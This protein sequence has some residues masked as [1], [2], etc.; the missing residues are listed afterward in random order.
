MTPNN[1]DPAAPRTHGGRPSLQEAYPDI[2]AEWDYERNGDLTPSKVTPGS[3]QKAGWVCKDDPDHRW[4]AKIYNRTNGT[5]CPL[6]QRK[7]DYADS[8]AALYP[9][10]AAEWD[11][12][13]NGDL[14]PAKVT[15]GSHQKAG[16]ICKDDPDHRWTATINNRTK[17]TGC[18]LCPR[19]VDY[20]DSLAALYP[21]IAAEWD[22]EKNGDLTPS[23]VTPGSNQKAGWICKDDPEHRWTATVKNRTQGTGCPV[24][25]QMGWIDKEYAEFLAGIGERI[26]DL[27]PAEIL[28]IASEHGLSQQAVKRLF[29]KVKNGKLAF[30]EPDPEPEPEPADPTQPHDPSFPGWVDGP[31]RPLDP[32]PAGP[33]VFLDPITGEPLDGDPPGDPPVDPP[34]D[35]T[36]PGEE[37]ST[38]ITVG[39]EI[40]RKINEDPDRARARRL[41]Q[42]LLSV[43][44]DVMWKAAYVSPDKCDRA[45]GRPRKDKYEEQIRTAFR[46]EFDAARELSIPD[47]WRFAVDGE[48]TEPNLMQRHVASTLAR[49]PYFAN[50]SGTGAGKTLS[51]VLAAMS[52][53]HGRG[54]GLV[55]VVC[56]HNTIDGWVRTVTGCDHTSQVATKTWNPEWSQGIGPKWLVL[57]YE[58][59][60]DEDAQR[61]IEALLQQYRI[62]M[63]IVDEIHFG[64]ERRHTPESIRRGNLMSLRVKAGEQN[65]KLRVLGMSA[66]PVINEPKEAVSLLEILQGIE[67]PDLPVASTTVAA[68]RLHQE[69]VLAG[70]RWKPDYSDIAVVEK[71]IDV[72]ISHLHEEL[73]DLG[74]GASAL[75]MEMILMRGKVDTV[76]DA[77]C[78]GGRTLVYTEFR[79]GVVPLLT[80][81]LEAAGLRVGHFT[82]KTKQ[83][84]AFLGQDPKTGVEVPEHQ[85][86]DVLI[87]TQAVAI[88]IDGL[89]QVADR[90]VFA[91]LP[92]TS[93]AY[94]QIVGRVVRQGREKS[95]PVEI[96]KPLTFIQGSP[97]SLDHYRHNTLR[98]KKTIADAII[99][100]VLPNGMRLPSKQKVFEALRT[101]I[102]RLSD[103]IDRTQKE[104]A[105]A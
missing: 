3:G 35:P 41:A 25:A 104:R 2:A 66:T 33:P 46:R 105:A 48:L 51:A 28:N 67:R 102:A 75:E 12:E 99:D 23:K 15:P 93:A 21:D 72:D 32:E 5:G 1:Q 27:T 58:K 24:H 6:C 54:R 100:G 91:T 76:V 10:I 89:Q 86:V 79:D 63:L 71:L 84:A 87:G 103:E 59:L 78:Q 83:L 50:W 85:Q 82:G 26:S 31:P 9:D 69:M 4:T 20:A 96:V 101:N 74:K 11:Y 16:W 40:L 80:D 65:R 94:E 44:V 47:E 8:L 77:C 70:T 34:G 60:S 43:R 64:K 61:D 73:L 55:V 95:R 88:G 97:W 37:L 17:G 53:K 92:W 57:N 90:L 19:K 62:D 68:L 56:P 98:T 81:A 7:V 52:L 30:P 38:A 18:P 39:G 13:K 49:R 42:Y 45:T 29:K 36:G 14:T 22:Y